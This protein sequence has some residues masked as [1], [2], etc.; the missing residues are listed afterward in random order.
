[1]KKTITLFAALL[2]LSANAQEQKPIDTQKVDQSVA[3][4]VATYK[5]NLQD[6]IDAVKRAVAQGVLTKDEGD[7]IIAKLEST[8]IETLASNIEYAVDME[9]FD[10]SQFE[11][12][13]DSIVQDAADA[14]DVQS[15]EVEEWDE[16]TQVVT[17][18]PTEEKHTIKNSWNFK[19]SGLVFGA[20]FAN[21]AQN[22]HFPDSEYSY[23]RSNNFEWGYMA[24][25]PFSKKN[26]TVGLK[27]GLT[28]N[29][30][31]LHATQNQ[32]FVKNGSDLSTEQFSQTLTKA[33]SYLRNTY[34]TIPLM[35][36][37]DF[38]DKYFDLETKKSVHKKGF[39]F[40]VGGYIGYN[41]NSKQFLKYE[42]EFGHTVKEKQKGEWNATDFQYGLQASVGYGNINLFAK[43]DLNDMFKQK[44]TD[45]N[46][47]SLGLR[48]ELFD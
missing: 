44:P 39:K 12:E 33:C 48:L 37:F 16:S 29:Y 31:Q 46:F 25:V 9:S 13:M 26:N 27:Y 22:N 3:E 28:F 15:W 36:D 18:E 11:I 24:R 6:K 1:M 34:I 21:L 40:G 38:S 23:A 42:N 8:K 32:Y 45:M 47:W 30:Y 7:K 14:V 43:Y 41:I 5:K 4:N 17:A 10:W 19:K 35:I 20:G 2:V